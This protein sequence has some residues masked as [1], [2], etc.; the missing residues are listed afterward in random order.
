[1]SVQGNRVVLKFADAT[2]GL[3]AKGGKLTGFT[4]AGADQKF[5]PAD[6]EI[7]GPDTI[8]VSAAG[9][10]QPEAVRFGWANYP[11]VNLWNKAGLPA[12]PFRTDTW[13]LLTQPK[14]ASPK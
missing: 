8:A 12:T 5:V 9:V 4:I 1:M 14:S 11:E 2:G 13:P 3:E 10:A 7:I 6:A